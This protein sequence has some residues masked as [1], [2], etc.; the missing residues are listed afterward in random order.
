MFTDPDDPSDAELRLWA[1]TPDAEEPSQD[2]DLMLANTGRDALIVAFASDDACPSRDWFLAVLYLMVG[3]AV[4]TGFVTL[5]E[6]G[7]RALLARAD[8]M[9]SARLRTWQ[10][11]SLQLMRDPASFDYDDWCAGGLARRADAG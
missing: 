7:V 11:R 6:P 2:F 4:R 9:D 3:D 1:Y 10:A 5:S 8:A